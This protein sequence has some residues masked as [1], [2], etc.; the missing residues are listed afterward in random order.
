VRSLV[1]ELPEPDKVEQVEGALAPAA[2]DDPAPLTATRL[3]SSKLSGA[4]MDLVGVV[5]EHGEVSWAGITA[6]TWEVGGQ[7]RA[8][9]L[10]WSVVARNP[11]DGRG[12]PDFV[13]ITSSGHTLSWQDQRVDTDV[14]LQHL[15]PAGHRCAAA[16]GDHWFVVDA[17]TGEL[18][19]DTDVRW[20]PA[21]TWVGIATAG[22]RL[23][24]AS[25]AGELVVADLA[26]RRVT[27]V[28]PVPLWPGPRVMYG[29]CST[30]LLGVGWY[31]TYDN[32]N[33]RAAVLDADGRS[34]GTLDLLKLVGG[35]T[36]VIEAVGAAGDQLA[37]AYASPR[38]RFLDT[39]RVAVTP[40]PRRMPL[41][42]RGSDS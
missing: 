36:S 38:G 33:G 20:L 42:R 11:V 6:A 5:G 3:G 23:V 15:L 32:A 40:P 16:I 27:G 9:Q 10:L 1:G 17:A 28:W 2:P 8:T 21:R 7:T 30:L 34:L 39:L 37:I 19:S 12:S 24:L 14:A 25:T 13:A 31:A 29:E 35:A 18:R 41:Q 26:T 4:L 22:E